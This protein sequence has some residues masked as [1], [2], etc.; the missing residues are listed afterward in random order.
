MV[1]VIAN[2]LQE[3]T[4]IVVD[5]VKSAPH[6]IRDAVFQGTVW[7]P[8]LW[9]TYFGDSGRVINDEGFLETL[10]ADDLNAYKE[11]PGCTPDALLLEELRRCQSKLHAWGASQQIQFDGDK[12]SMH[13]LDREHPYGESFKFLGVR[14]D[15]KLTMA[16]ACLEIAAQGHSRTRS[17]LR[18]QAFYSKSKMIMFCKAQV[19]SY[20]EMWTPAVRHANEYWL[21]A[22]DGVQLA[23]LNELD[24]GQDVGL[25]EFNLAPLASRRDMAMLG[26]IHKIVLGLAPVSLAA[27]FQSDRGGRFPRSLR[28]Q[29]SRHSRQVRDPIDGTQHRML[30]RSAFGLAYAYNLLPEHV[31]QCSSVSSFQTLLQ[32][33]LVNY[34]RA[35]CASWAMLYRSGIK[36]L[37][38]ANFQALF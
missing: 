8:P 33:G 1:K 9:N 25:T 24:I 20:I 10:F 32:R 26:M 29:H 35:G 14:Y 23:F 19:L 6:V 30:E 28:A 21:S 5:G 11:Y 15:T 22:I 38:T 17:L 7:G 37:S 34:C 3:R 16:T 27:L 2:W 31:V 36:S 18:L 12:E 13:I 4:A